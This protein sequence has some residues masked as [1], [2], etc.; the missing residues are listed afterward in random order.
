M[1]EMHKYLS[2]FFTSDRILRE[3]NF[4]S[5][6]FEHA[7]P[8]FHV[9]LEYPSYIVEFVNGNPEWKFPLT[10]QAPKYAEYPLQRKLWCRR[11]R[12]QFSFLPT[13]ALSQKLYNHLSINTNSF[14]TKSRYSETDRSDRIII[15]D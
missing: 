15:N 14:A 7:R 6:I 4:I 2:F 8:S 13:C 5:S 3:S 1:S 12:D 11:S 10:L 9:S